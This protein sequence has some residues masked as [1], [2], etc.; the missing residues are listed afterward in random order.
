M[1]FLDKGSYGYI[2][3]YKKNKL[4][5]ITVLML[6]IAFVVVSLLLMFATTKNVLV[7]VAILLA[8]PLAKFI[9]LYVLVAG[10]KPLP[11]EDY[12]K[13]C[14]DYPELVKEL[15][16]DVTVSRYEGVKFFQ[17]FLV[18]NGGIYGLCSP[19]KGEKLK[20][21]ETWIKESTKA[22]YIVQVFDSKE[23]F[24][25]KANSISTPNDKTKGT[26]S[27]VRKE[28]LDMVV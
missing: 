25:K 1:K 7:I 8:L 11:K 2:E 18:K 15:K 21:Y 13:L 20:D 14:N 28:F 3:N 17:A 4:I 26:D 23:K 27:R 19:K 5:I 12:E 6:M 24:L 10:F 9:T 22:Q 16:Y